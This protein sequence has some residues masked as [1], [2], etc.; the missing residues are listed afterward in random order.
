MPP[1]AYRWSVCIERVL[2]MSNSR[3]FA[4]IFARSLDLADLATAIDDLAAGAFA[5]VA[6]FDMQ[7]Q[8]QIRVR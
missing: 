8:M 3:F 1:A 6:I 5:A 2:A 4:A 7:Q